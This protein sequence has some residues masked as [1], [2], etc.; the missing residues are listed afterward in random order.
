MKTLLTL[1]WR[2]L[3]RKKR[4]T[5]ITLSSVMFATILAIVLMSMISGM[6]E[7]MVDSIVRN[8]TGYLQIQD[9]L[10]HDEPSMDHALEYGDE[11]KDALAAFPEEISYTVPRIG[12]F[13]LAAKDMGTRG[14]MVNGIDPEKEDRMND[15]SSNMV[16]GEMFTIDDDYAVI[17]EGLA[18][19]LEVEPGESIVLLGQGFQGMTAVGTYRIGGFIEF[20]MPEQ[21]NT[22]V[23]LPL[24]QAQYFFAAPDRLTNLII[25]TEDEDI[26]PELARNLEN[27]LDPEWYTVKTWEELM[28]DK[29]AAFEAREAQVAI[30]AWVLYIVVGFGIFG[31]IMTMLFERLREFGILLSIGL[32]RLQLAAICMIETLIIS[33]LGVFAGVTAG[34]LIV[35][36]LHLNPV[37]LGDELGDIMIDMGFEP[38][39]SFSIAPDIF[40]Y[41]GMVIFFIALIVGLYPVTRVLRMDMVHASRN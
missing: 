14:V 4:R 7:Q 32:K 25:M 41:Q 15:L 19:L 27:N 10:Y 23:Y 38:V 31:T 28:P 30:F 24:K 29:L 22:M 40:L 5:F 35:L 20:F 3:W 6:Q 39:F 18:S 21:N 34:F 26:V 11:V 9:V 16:K 1:A 13:A 37:R 8:T 12:G 2:N 33:F 36:R 17:A